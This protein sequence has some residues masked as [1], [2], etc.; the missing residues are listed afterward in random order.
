MATGMQPETTPESRDANLELD[1]VNSPPHYT[2]GPVEVIDLVE[3]FNLDY[4]EGNA[5]KYLLR[6]RRKG[7][8][9]DLEKCI[10]YIRRIIA[11][12]QEGPGSTAPRGL[13]E[14]LSGSRGFCGEDHLPTEPPDA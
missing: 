4:H 11:V 3:L 9:Q 8:V 7:G 13:K 14:E 5:L 1:M 12:Q 6:W 2:H 10:W